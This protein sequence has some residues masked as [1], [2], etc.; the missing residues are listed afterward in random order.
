LSKSDQARQCFILNPTICY[1]TWTSLKQPRRAR[2]TELKDIELKSITVSKEEEKK[3][4]RE[5]VAPVILQAMKRMKGN[6]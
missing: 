1:I 3:A 4:K 5:V 6:K 2:K